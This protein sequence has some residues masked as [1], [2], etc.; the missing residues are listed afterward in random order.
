MAPEAFLWADANGG[1]SP[2]VA[3]EV[4]PRLADVGV[5]V[6][7]APIQP[8]RISGYRALKKQGALPILMDEGVISPV[9]LREF[10]EL[11]MLDG[12]AMK[13]ARCG[14]LL[15]GRR[16]IELIEERG[17]MWLGSGLTDPDLSLAATLVLYGAYGLK[18]PAA[19]NG[20][21]FLTASLLKDE[22]EVKDGALTPPSNPGLGV[23][24]DEEKL[25]ALVA[26]TLSPRPRPAERRVPALDLRWQQV[27]GRSL[28]LM[29]GD[30]VLWRFNHAPDAAQ[31]YF[32][33]LALPGTG[34]LTRN[35]PK[36]HVWHHGLWFSWKYIN[37]INYWEHEKGGT[38]P[39]GR[40][41][42]EMERIEAR[43]D[44]S[45]LMRMKL[46]YGHG[47]QTPVLAEER[48]IEVT[49]PAADGSY[50]IDWE[51]RFTALA[52]TVVLDRTPPPNEPG[53]VAWGGYAGLSL[54]LANFDQRA[55]VTPAGEVTFNR[56]NRYRGR[57]SA[58]E[59][60]GLSAG[61]PVGIAV[62]DRAKN[63]NSPF[64]FGTPFVRKP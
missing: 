48:S 39:A 62:L 27:D 64:P 50:T 36:D 37:G 63:P 4:A 13:P 35:A 41:S 11:G 56:Q 60:S 55:A 42:L 54:R 51:G 44:H 7:E 24:I 28:T 26:A 61:R 53:G 31:S 45:A 9:E 33:P 34:A 32:H 14:G 12:V 20:P 25:A 2:E 21:Q 57:H 22:F 1:Y 18:R 46:V 10:I 3:L 16:Q 40:T 49:S 29:T 38:R 15:S 30:Q 19:L 59:Y 47:T 17:L 23:E 5:D 43:P 8:N 6:L 58:F 52:E